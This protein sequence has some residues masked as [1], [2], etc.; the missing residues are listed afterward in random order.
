MPSFSSHSCHVQY[1]HLFFTGKV[2]EL[3][4]TPPP[5]LPME[6][7]S[8]LLCGPT[9]SKPDFSQDWQH[10]QAPESLL[11]MQNLV[12]WWLSGLRIWRCDYCGLGH[13][14]GTDS[15]P[16]PGNF[17]VLCVQQKQTNK[18][19]T[20]QPNKQTKN[21]RSPESQALPQTY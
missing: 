8:L 20:Q 2:C 18:Q 10:Q 15:I 13:C 12:P 7:G 19:K 21:L 5:H 6:R 16:G 9:A 3:F 11:E 14:C 1:F 17:H 4:L